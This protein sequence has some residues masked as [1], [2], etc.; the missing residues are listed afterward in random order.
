MD[1]AA[2]Y[3]STGLLEDEICLDDA[4]AGTK[5]FEVLVEAEVL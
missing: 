1:E 4:G 2:A 5:E 3:S